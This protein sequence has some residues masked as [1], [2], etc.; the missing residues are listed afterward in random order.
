MKRLI[1]LLLVL[2]GCTRSQ[3]KTAVFVPTATP[4]WLIVRPTREIPTVAV[5]EIAITLTALSGQSQT[6]LPQSTPTVRQNVLGAVE[7]SQSCRIKG[8]VSKRNNDE[9]I[10]H[11][12][13]WR[14]YDRTEVN[15]KEGD[16]WFCSET[17]AIAAGFRKPQ[18]VTT[19]CIP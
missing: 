5:P 11:C 4:E 18:N 17:D 16:R 19:P 7:Q 14:D 6:T 9:K 8:N 12:P 15:H 3:P 2:T 13:N 10:Y 1:L